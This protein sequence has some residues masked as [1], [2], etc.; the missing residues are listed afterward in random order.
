MGGDLYSDDCSD[1]AP[2]DDNEEPETDYWPEEIALG[3]CDWEW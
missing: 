1:A 2:P 3:T